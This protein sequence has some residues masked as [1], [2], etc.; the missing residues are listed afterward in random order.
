MITLWG[1][2]K[3]KTWARAFEILHSYFGDPP[4]T[5]F[6]IAPTSFSSPRDGRRRNSADKWEDG[7]GHSL[8]ICTLTFLFSFMNGPAKGKNF[9]PPQAIEGECN[10]ECQ[11]WLVVAFRHD[12]RP[13]L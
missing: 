9:T 2:K 10:R 7:G 1:I 4:L 5:Y 6:A 8:P 12:C 11:L 13:Y 3:K